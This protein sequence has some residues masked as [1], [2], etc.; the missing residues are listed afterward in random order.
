MLQEQRG[1]F[2]EIDHFSHCSPPYRM[3]E[4]IRHA[5]GREGIPAAE[6]IHIN[7]GEPPKRGAA[8][9]RSLLPTKDQRKRE[10]WTDTHAGRVLPEQRVG[11][12]LLNRKQ[13]GLVGPLCSRNPHDETVVVRRAQ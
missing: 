1:D 2:V 11:R 7:H 4:G 12:G 9:E 3:T 5:V 10:E 6:R 13:C 8:C